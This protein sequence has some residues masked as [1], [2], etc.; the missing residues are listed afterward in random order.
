MI[1]PDGKKEK[2]PIFLETLEQFLQY[3]EQDIKDRWEWY[4]TKYE[5]EIKK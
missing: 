1:Y 3:A 4:R 5:K 2:H